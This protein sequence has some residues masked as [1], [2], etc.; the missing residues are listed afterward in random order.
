VFEDE[1]ED[2]AEDTLVQA[3]REDEADELDPDPEVHAGLQEL[4]KLRELILGFIS[5]LAC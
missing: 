4:M 1:D 3:A 5:R 2:D